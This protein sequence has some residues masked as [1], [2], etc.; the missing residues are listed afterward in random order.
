MEEERKRVRKG[1]DYDAEGALRV[2]LALRDDFFPT[3][4]N[5]SV[6][7]AAEECASDPYE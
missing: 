3:T 2:Q 6:K 4:P 7:G 5:R 1:P